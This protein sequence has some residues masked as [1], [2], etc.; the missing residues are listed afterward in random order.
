MVD[1]DVD[2]AVIG[3]GSGGVR[4][5]RVAAG[6]GARVVVAEGDR[7]GGTCVIRGCVPKK[8]MV[9]A[10]GFQHEIGN[11]AGFGWSI[12]SATFDWGALTAN[13]DRE[14]AR[15]EAAYTSTI[16]KSGARL[17]KARA[18]F[19]DAHTLRLSDGETLRARNILIATGSTPNHGE[20]I[21][22]IQHVISSDE[23]FE[24]R[25]LPRRILIQGGG[26]IAV[27]FA[28][29]F[30]GL[31]SK[32]TLV[33]RSDNVLR[34]FDEDIRTHVRSTLEREGITVFTGCRIEKVDKPDGS[35]GVLSADL[36]NA[37]QIVADQVM[38]AIGRRPNIQ[39]L[40]LQKSGV[41]LSPDSGGVA[42]DENSRTNVPHIYAV[43]DVT[44]RV[45]LTP[46]A[47][48]EA[49]AF[50]DSIFGDRPAQVD[51]TDIPTAVFSRP[52]VGSVG[53]SEAQACA[54]FDRVDIY[55]SEFRPMKA[56]LS[57]GSEQ[58]MMKLVVDADSGRVVGC[59]IVGS[60]AAEIIQAVAIA[61]KMKASK[62][63]FDATMA[64]HPTAAEELLTMRMPTRRCDT[65]RGGPPT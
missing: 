1:F 12:P 62:G 25:E 10:S 58:M 32:V 14:V 13:R 49:Q 9:Y 4:A 27:E 57:R 22:G 34:G 36:S 50:A 45:N 29:I 41:A 2:L 19:Q 43:G 11:A 17:V 23:V 46:V 59:H 52:E 42:V 48:R 37:E 61:I 26:Y 28:C 44:N 8:L 65:A 7:V 3:G 64:L 31:G 30:A 63:D 40:N 38:F 20:P 51:H 35:N 18:A 5:A 60:G 21:P 47:V 55:K 54:R 24:L 39:D 33:C 16:E 56:A 6:Y 15:L 53:L